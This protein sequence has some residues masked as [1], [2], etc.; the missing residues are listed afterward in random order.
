[1]KP[2]QPLRNQQATATRRKT[3]LH[4][5]IKTSESIHKLN[6]RRTSV[7]RSFSFATVRRFQ[8][9]SD[10]NWAYALDEHVRIGAPY[11]HYLTKKEI[12]R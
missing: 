11:K 12:Y 7:A 4:R 1:M 8:N 6:S 5:F 3:L 10:P 9:C 2:T